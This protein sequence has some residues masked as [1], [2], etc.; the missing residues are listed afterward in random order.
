MKKTSKTTFRLPLYFLVGLIGVVFCGMGQSLPGSSIEDLLLIAEQ[1]T[2]LETLELLVKNLERQKPL[3]S[4][5]VALLIG[6]LEH[7]K[8]EVQRAAVIALGNGK[9]AEAVPDLIN[10]LETLSLPNEDPGNGEAVKK[11]I[12]EALL[13]EAIAISLSF[14]GDDRAIGPL[15]NHP[16]LYTLHMGTTPLSAFGNRMLLRCLNIVRN[17]QDSRHRDIIPLITNLRDAQAIPQ[18]LEFLQGDDP[19]IRNAAL[20]ALTGMKAREAIPMLEELLR[21]QEAGVRFSALQALV[22]MQPGKYL[23]KA[24]LFLQ[25]NSAWVRSQTID[26]LIRLGWR[27]DKVLLEKLLKDTDAIVQY[28]AARTLKQLSGKTFSYKRTKITEL[29]EKFEE[30][31]ARR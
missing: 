13:A 12:Q 14:I 5:E 6:A 15:L 22:E 3:N 18:L 29:L 30:P 4:T 24:L 11:L 17:P 8:W 19:E 26:L 9:A 7:P 16:E 27:G 28:K 20:A 25:D 23:E 2:D 10:K 31:V 21:N 1:T